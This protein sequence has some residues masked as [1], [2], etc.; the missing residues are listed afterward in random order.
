MGLQTVMAIVRRV[1]ALTALVFGIATLI[2]GSRVLA[3]EDP[4]YVVFRPLLIYNTLMGAVYVGTGILIW[5]GTRLGTRMAWA[6][7][8]LNGIVLAG[9]A[10]LFYFG[11]GVALD[12]VYAMVLRTA[13]WAVISS[14]LVFSDRRVPR[15]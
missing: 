13:V 14:G 11:G 10:Y 12:S 4:G 8:I 6:I 15:E 3:G 7:A 5:R 1:L 9:I 2:A